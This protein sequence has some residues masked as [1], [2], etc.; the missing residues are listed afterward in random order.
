MPRNLSRI[1]PS[2]IENSLRICIDPIFQEPS[3]YV[4]RSSNNLDLSENKFELI[5]NSCTVDNELVE[6]IKNTKG[7][8]LE[9][10]E[11]YSPNM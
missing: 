11:Q 3:T 2:L 4:K 1:I 9:D 10:I 6:K 7:Y 8:D 5:F